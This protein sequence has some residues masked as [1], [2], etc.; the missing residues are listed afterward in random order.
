LWKTLLESCG[1]ACVCT[2]FDPL[3]ASPAEVLRRVQGSNLVR[4]G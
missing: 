3:H 2:E 1:K 4:C